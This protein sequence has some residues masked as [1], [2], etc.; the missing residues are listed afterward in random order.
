MT[1]EC[2]YV[3]ATPSCA[4]KSSSSYLKECKYLPKQTNR[5]N[6]LNLIPL[7]LIIYI[8]QNGPLPSLHP[9]HLR[10]GI[11]LP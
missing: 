11:L 1:N 4:T 3:P 5:A 2:M 8:M 9:H 10:S 7:T 6:K